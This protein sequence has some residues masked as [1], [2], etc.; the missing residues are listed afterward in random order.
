MFSQNITKWIYSAVILENQCVLKSGR[1]TVD[2]SSTRQ[3]L[4]KC[5]EHQIALYQIFVDLTLNLFIGS[6]SRP[7]SAYLDDRLNSSTCLCDST[8]TGNSLSEPISIDNFVN[9]TEIL[10]QTLIPYIF[11]NSHVRLQN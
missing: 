4:E 2:N 1:V 3:L 6:L 10:S 8:V 9:Q 5:I 7:F 11:C